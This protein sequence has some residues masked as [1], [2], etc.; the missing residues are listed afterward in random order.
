M[1][2][3]VIRVPY[4]SISLRFRYDWYSGGKGIALSATKGGLPLRGTRSGVR[5]GK[6]DWCG[7]ADVRMCGRA[8]V[9]RLCV[10]VFLPYGGFRCSG[11]ASVSAVRRMFAVWRIGV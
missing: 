11:N 9:E 7:R 10:Q 1:V 5:Q 4:W 6:A 8:E 2:T 3:D